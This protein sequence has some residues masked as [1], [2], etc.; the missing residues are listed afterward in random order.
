MKRLNL[1]DEYLS[2]IQDP[3]LVTNPVGDDDDES[4]VD[5]DGMNTVSSSQSI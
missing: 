2:G 4:D 1:L 5:D 3:N